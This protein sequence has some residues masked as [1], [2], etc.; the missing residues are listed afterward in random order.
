MYGRLVLLALAA[1]V[2]AGCTNPDAA[3]REDAAYAFKTNLVAETERVLADAGGVLTLSNALELAHARSL[4]LAQQDLEAKLARINRASAFSAFLPTVGLSGMGLMAGGK[5]DDLPYLGDLENSHLR[6]RSASL[7]VA[8]PV[9][10]PVAWVMFAESQYGVRIKDIVHE[11]AAQLLDVQVAALFYQTAV[12]ERR[13]ETAERQLES[14]RALTNRVTRLAAEGYA[15]PADAARAA[16]RCVLAETSLDAARNDATAA[17]E[18]LAGLLHLWPLATFKVS[19]ESLL[20]L[21]PLPEKRVEEWVWDGLVSRKDLA[22]GDQTLELRK[23]QVIEALAG[24]LPNAVLGGGG[25]SGSIEDVALRGWA[26]SLIGTWA[27]FEGFRTVQQYRAAKATRE[28]EFKLQ[29]ERMTAVVIAVADSWRQR[30][31]VRQKATAARAW[32]EAARLDYEAAARRHEDGQDT[33]SSVLDKLAVREDAETKLAESAYGE[34]MSD[35]LL[36]QAV[37][38]DVIESVSSDEKEI[39]TE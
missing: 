1:G 12:A 29:E 10:T 2:L 32:A 25:L 8:Q 14:A 38:I 27:I 15:T 30:R 19:G 39:G 3:Y 23:A 4:K 31:R 36:R 26:G 21:P 24:F 20:A 18:E 34:A 35:I 6:A 9:F 11:R 7:V 13:V 33:L 5:I 37:G 28:T 16:A 22:A 17:R